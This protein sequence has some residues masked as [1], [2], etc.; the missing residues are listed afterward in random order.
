MSNCDFA[1]DVVLSWTCSLRGGVLMATA[2]L[3]QLGFESHRDLVQFSE[4]Q[5]GCR[6]EHR[7]R[8]KA[9]DKAVEPAA[10]DV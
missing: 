9:S 5:P 7:R 6:R 3:T 4:A 10:S 2:W 8:T 1:N